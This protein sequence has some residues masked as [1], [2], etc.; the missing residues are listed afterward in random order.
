MYSIKRTS[1][2]SAASVFDQVGELIVIDAAQHDRI[3]LEF[4]KPR[5]RAAAIPASTCACVSRPASAENLSGRSVSRLSVTRC[6]PAARSA[7]PCSAN[8]TPLVV[9][10]RSRIRGL[11]AS[12]R[13]SCGKIA[14]Q[15]RFA[16]RKPHVLNAQRRKHLDQPR[17]FLKC[18][19]FLPRQPDILLLR[20]AVV[21]AQV[22]PVGDRNAQAAQRT[23]QHV[24]QRRT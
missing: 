9:S 18:Q 11:A 6:N 17:N 15:Q 14:A 22:A 7:S 20:H 3:Q 4:R 2:S 5:R 16:P 23:A 21:A 8:R 13:T 12:I 19:Q 24:S 1:A 10:A